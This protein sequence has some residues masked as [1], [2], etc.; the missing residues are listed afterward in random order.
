VRLLNDYLKNRI[1]QVQLRNYLS[2][3]YNVPSGIGQG[4]AL[5]PLLFSLYINDIGSA[6]NIDYVM[7]ADDIVLF[8]SSP[9][10]NDAITE[11]NSELEKLHSWCA[12]LGLTISIDKTKFMVLHK[13]N[14][15]RFKFDQEVIINGQRIEQVYQF[16]YL[17]VWIDSGLTFT[18]HYEHV[19][20][21]LSAALGRLNNFKRFVSDPILKLLLNAYVDSIVN[22]C[23][24]IW[25]VQSTET[26]N[27]LFYKILRFLVHV[28]HTSLIKKC[29]KLRIRNKSK[30]FNFKVNDLIRKYKLMSVSEKR[31]VQLFRFIYDCKFIPQMSDWF[32]LSSRESR[33]WPLLTAPEIAGSSPCST[34]Y[35]KS[36]RYRGWK[37]WNSLT[38]LDSQVATLSR[39]EQFQAVTDYVIGLRNDEYITL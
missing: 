34:T 20:S 15:N 22:F 8:T 7:Y 12:R 5:G 25:A 37:F 18:K 32:L 33:H 3:Y 38:T 39:N 35:N 17:G 27:L 24:T 31:D 9:N 29:V 16:K 1:S 14:D 23:I 26:L 19:N 30:V 13:P 2:S 11:M 6:L 36:V 28:N 21:R 4:S 10:V